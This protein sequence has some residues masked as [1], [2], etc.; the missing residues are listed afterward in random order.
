MIRFVMPPKA[1]DAAQ[2]AEAVL[3]QLE[4]FLHSKALRDL[5]AILDTDADTFED[6]CN[7]RRR[8]NGSIVELQELGS[9][10]LLNEK[11][12]MLYPLFRELGFIDINKPVNDKHS[13]IVVLGGSLNACR[14]RTE[15]AKKWIDETTGY[16]DGLACYRPIG[17]A[18]RNKAPSWLFDTEFGAMS[19]SFVRSFD[20]DRQG[21]N[22]EFKSDR[23]LNGI[24]C[25]RDLGRADKR[26]YRIFAA[27][28]SEPH[29]R[30]ADTADTLGFYYEHE[31]NIDAKDHILFITNNRHCNR[32]FLQLAYCMIKN[33]NPGIIDVIGCYPDERVTSA[34]EYDPFLYL[35]D[36]IG[37]MDWIKRFKEQV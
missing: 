13:R 31:K 29:Q 35:Q 10:E 25:I 23:N 36:L 6:I 37:I 20:L 28:S 5:F 22:E 1:L 4:E 12:E 2:K 9:S 32:Q 21:F 3:G 24:S 11:K 33:D 30:R 8:S 16:V 15:C 17:S 34:D 27:P 18:E 14:E 19:E 7:G 26:T